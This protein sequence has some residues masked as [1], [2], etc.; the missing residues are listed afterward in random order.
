MSG[1]S[2]I[3]G[4]KLTQSI[5][6]FILLILLSG[7]I[8]VRII[9]GEKN[10]NWLEVNL[11]PNVTEVSPT[12]SPS[13][14][15]I[16]TQSGIISTPTPGIIPDTWYFIAVTRQG[17]TMTMYLNGLAVANEDLY[18]L[19]LDAP[20]TLKFGR[21]EGFQGFFLNGRI[22]EVE[23]YNGIALTPLE[24]FGLYSTG[25]FGKCKGSSTSPCLPPPIGLTSW[26]PGEG[27][28][29]DMISSRYGNF[30]GGAT[31]GPGLEGEAFVFDGENDYVE[32]AD[33]PVLNF[34][35]GDFTID[36]WVNFTH[37]NVDQV[38]IEKWIQG[39]SQEHTYSQ[40]W[41][42]FMTNYQ[43]LWFVMDD[44]SGG[45]WDINSP[46]GLNPSA[47]PTITPTTSPT[48][49]PI[50][51]IAQTS[52]PTEPKLPGVI[53]FVCEVYLD[54]NTSQICMMNADGSNY[55]RLTTDDSIRYMDPRIDPQGHYLIY[56]A[57]IAG[58]FQLFRM[59]PDLPNDVEQLTF[60]HGDS[61]APSISPDG[62]LI[63]YTFTQGD[64]KSV[65]I[66]DQQT[67][68]SWQIY[69]SPVANG[70]NPIWSFD[71]SQ[72][73]FLAQELNYVQL[74]VMNND[75]LN[76]H[77]IEDP[78]TYHENFAWSPDGKQVA[79]AVGKAGE[80]SIYIFEVDDSLRIPSPDVE[81]KKIPSMSVDGSWIANNVYPDFSPD[82]KWITYTVYTERYNNNS[83]EIFVYNLET[84]E[85]IRLTDNIYCDYKPDWGP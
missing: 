57:L 42:L 5:S 73:M 64:Y 3:K 23:I 54:R 20:I 48:S 56:S 70:W 41:S 21:R 46:S 31:I 34:G 71:G 77:Q 39:D 25:R 65:R 75:G 35:T 59:P 4:L 24:I 74:Y 45:E 2:S 63:A 67:L 30:M 58:N 37:I 22:D 78:G 33:D 81:D 47:T 52:R 40:G 15:I 29:Q 61:T 9:D 11:L 8:T 55:H 6:I 32:V 62:M 17:R 1:P 10:P 28:A 49:A 14:T 26:W 79:M 43:D 19:N 36:L 84:A 51:S 68:K 72:I 50:R 53:V 16:S 18:P 60:D 12:L 69:G 82:G 83:C 27:S 80:R 44:G 85:N 7:C 76:Y 66:L 38:L 13:V